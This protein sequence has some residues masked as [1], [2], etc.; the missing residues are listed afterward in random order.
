MKNRTVVVQVAKTISPFSVDTLFNPVVTGVQDNRVTESFEFTFPFTNIEFD[1]KPIEQ[2][3]PHVCIIKIYGLSKETYNQIGVTRSLLE[4]S[5]YTEYRPGK[6]FYGYT[7]DVQEV[8]YGNVTMTSF[9][10]ERG[11]TV[12]TIQLD[13]QLELFQNQLSSVS[14]AIALDMASFVSLMKVGFPN[15]TILLSP[16]VLPS[17]AIGRLSATGSIEDILAEALHGKYSYNVYKSI[18]TIYKIGDRINN[19]MLDINGK[20]GLLNMPKLTS[21][22]KLVKVKTKLLPQIMEGA[23]VRI[24][25][26]MQDNP[27]A[28]AGTKTTLEVM[29]WSSSF[30]GGLGFSEAE[31]RVVDFTL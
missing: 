8:F 12:T 14:S 15:F 26:V 30:K 5:L 11:N 21:E 31:C 28:I 13:H 25:Y 10:I 9:E 23:Y 17:T 3:K 1:I 16:S 18:V 4:S 19:I 20:N 22:N 24:P 27:L 2:G 7:D 29:N 6:V